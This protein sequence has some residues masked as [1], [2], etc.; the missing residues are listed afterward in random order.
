MT[1]PG[2]RADRPGEA[3]DVPDAPPIPGLSFRL[4]RHAA[5]YEAIATLIRDA[6]VADGNDYVPTAENVQIEAENDAGF[7]PRTGYVLAELDGRLVAVG[8]AFVQVRDGVTVYTSS[9]TVHPSVRR[10]GLGRAILRHNEKVLRGIADTRTDEGGRTFGAWSSEREAG[11]DALLASEGYAP[12]RYGFSMIRDLHSPLPDAALPTGLEVHPVLPEHHRPIWEADAE[13]FRDHWGHR[14]W[15][16]E[17]FRALFSQPDLD[18]SL[19]RVAWDGDEVVG[20]VQT[21]IWQAE[22]EALGV[23]RGWLEHISVRRPWRG[24]GVAR[25][26]IVSALE[27]LRAAGMTE[28]MLGVDAENLTGALRLYEGLG[29][30]VKDRGATYRKAWSAE[31]L[32]EGCN[33]RAGATEPD[34]RSDAT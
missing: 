7:D 11:S 31:H 24:R 17:D 27:G 21:W 9:G 13:A 18:T 20:S 2:E 1:A 25:A 16:E 22:N 28:A 29:F 33:E 34:G 15:T 6:S 8:Q 12:V 26:L 3:L 4:F 30:R 14:E 5:D 23:R 32:P 10:R 19:W